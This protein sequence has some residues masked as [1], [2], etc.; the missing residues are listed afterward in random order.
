MFNIYKFP[1]PLTK[2]TRTVALVVDRKPHYPIEATDQMDI[3]D[4]I[5][6]DEMNIIELDRVPTYEELYGIECQNYVSLRGYK[7]WILREHPSMQEL[8]E[9][10]MLGFYS[11]EAAGRL[12]D[13]LTYSAQN[14]SNL[15]ERLYQLCCEEDAIVFISTDPAQHSF[16]FTVV[17]RDKL[18]AADK[19][20]IRNMWNGAITYMHHVG[21]IHGGLIMHRDGD[22]KPSWSIHT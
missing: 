10:Q 7:L 1:D 3:L 8:V 11:F 9:K 12:M 17:N 14:N 20:I 6:A 15:H 19:S 13:A 18:R 16:Y 5:S 21:G 2:N 4:N 22:G